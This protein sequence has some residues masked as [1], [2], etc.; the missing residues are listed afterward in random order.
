MRDRAKVHLGA[1]K[2]FLENFALALKEMLENRQ[3][4][5]K[6][7]DFAENI[8][9]L[10]DTRGIPVNMIFAGSDEIFSSDPEKNKAF[11]TRIGLRS[12]FK[13]R[14]VPRQSQG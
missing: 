13:C 6:Q 14:D 11:H 12:Q 2:F 7:S 3:S 4:P 10:V 1:P 8:I 5:E 9:E